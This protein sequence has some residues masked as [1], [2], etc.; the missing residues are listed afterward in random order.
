[1]P[2]FGS[3]GAASGRGF[4]FTSGGQG[5]YDVDYVVVAGGGNSGNSSYA[6]GTNPGAGAG[7]YRVSYNSASY[8]E[9]SVSTVTVDPGSSYTI[10]VG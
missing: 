7:G 8:D 2:L 10:T 6:F 1:M 5:P 3:F 9:P 4:G